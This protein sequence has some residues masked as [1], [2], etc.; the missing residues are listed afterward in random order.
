MALAFLMLSENLLSNRWRAPPLSVFSENLNWPEDSNLCSMFALRTGAL[1]S[2][3]GQGFFAFARQTSG[4]ED[5][6]QRTEEQ[7]PFRLHWDCE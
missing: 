7:L 2:M 1:S 3:D 5:G 6:L 4:K